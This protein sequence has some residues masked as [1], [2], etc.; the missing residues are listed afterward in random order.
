MNAQTPTASLI[1]IIFPLGVLLSGLV[2]GVGT[3]YPPPAELGR[4]ASAAK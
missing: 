2:K 4:I 1:A 3:I